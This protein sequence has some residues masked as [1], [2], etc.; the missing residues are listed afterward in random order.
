M[1]TIPI[2][3]RIF[4]WRHTFHAFLTLIN[5]KLSRFTSASN[6]PIKDMDT[7]DN[8]SA[9]HN[10]GPDKAAKLSN[11][12]LH[13]GAMGGTAW[14]GACWIITGLVYPTAS[15]KTSAEFTVTR[16]SFPQMS[17]DNGTNWTCTGKEP[18]PEPSGCE[19]TIRTAYPLYYRLLGKMLC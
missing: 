15:I 18:N 5:E 8:I 10:M 3:S 2:C 1:P 13:S 17:S 9:T 11:W 4:Y 7:H 6:A 19:A 16:S 14:T 12:Q